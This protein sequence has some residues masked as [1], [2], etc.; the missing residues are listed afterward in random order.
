MKRLQVIVVSLLVAWACYGEYRLY[1][2]R[3]NL[4]ELAVIVA[5]HLV[6]KDKEIIRKLDEILVELHK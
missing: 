3:K 2:T 6:I 4:E 1:E 5:E